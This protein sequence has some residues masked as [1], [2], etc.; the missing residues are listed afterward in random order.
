MPSYPCSALPSKAFQNYINSNSKKDPKKM[1][2]IISK[3]N[4][5]GYKGQMVGNITITFGSAS[6]D[7]CSPS[8][9]WS[10]IGSDSNDSSPSMNLGFIDPPYEDFT[11]N[12]VVYPYKDFQNATRNNCELDTYSVRPNCSPNSDPNCHGCNPAYIAG[13]TVIH[14]FGHLLSLV[15]EQSN[16]LF[17]KNPIKLNKEKVDAYYRG[18]GMTD[19]DAYS[20]SIIKYSDPNLY[21]GSVFDPDSI[22]LYFLPSDWFEDFGQPNFKNP[23]KAN[24]KLSTIDKQ[25]LVKEYPMSAATF[26]N[27]TVNFID[28]PHT[29]KWKMAWVQKTILE[30]IAPLVGITWSFINTDGSQITYKPFQNPTLFLTLPALPDIQQTLQPITENFTNIFDNKPIYLVIILL[31]ILLFLLIK[32]S[33]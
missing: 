32:D 16:D 17:G 20:N 14:E 33:R 25:W 6:C 1:G 13:A 24:F 23:T 18:I 5:W 7:G 28:G 9:S 12:G 27:L 29:P 19:A 22:M 30:N 15:H 31:V 11:F 4:V 21:E 8:A 10:L 3:A 26:P 2:E